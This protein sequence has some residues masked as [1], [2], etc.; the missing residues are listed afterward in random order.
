M[1]SE[2]LIQNFY[3]AFQAKDYKT[4]QESYASDAIFNDEVFSNLNGTEAGKMWEM[5]VKNGKDLELKFEILSSEEDYVN[6]RWIAKYTF[7]KT[8]RLVI[9]DIKAFFKIENGKIIEHTDS[10]DFYK[11]A[12]QAF[13]L[14]GLLIGWTPFFK[15]KVQKTAMG[16]LYKFLERN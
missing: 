11:W 5:L 9:N 6:A 14:T 12:R 8:G 15:N 4:M 10:F 1:N 13:G 7:S 3:K 16:S 2:T